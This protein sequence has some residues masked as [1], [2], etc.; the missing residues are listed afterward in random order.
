MSAV[1]AAAV[2]VG[3]LVAVVIGVSLTY[4]NGRK[5]VERIEGVRE[6]VNGNHD[7]QTRRINQLTKALQGSNTAVPAADEPER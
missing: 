5:I 3:V 4:R 7:E 1:L 2:Y 6:L